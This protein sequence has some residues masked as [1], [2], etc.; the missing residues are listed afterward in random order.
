[1]VLRKL[2]Q[3]L[4]MQVYAWTVFPLSLP[5][6]PCQEACREPEDHNRQNSSDYLFWF[7]IWCNVVD[8][9]R[10]G[11]FF[12][13]IEVLVERIFQISR[14]WTRRLRLEEQR[15]QRGPVST[16]KTDR[17]HD[18]RQLSSDWRSW[19]SIRFSWFILRYSRWWPH[20]GIRYKM[21]RSCIVDVKISIRWYLG[22]SVQM[23][24]TWVCAAQNRIGIVRHGDSPEHIS[25]HL[26]KVENHGE[27][28]YRS[29]TSIAK[30]WRQ[31]RENWIRIRGKESKGIPSGKK[32]ASVRIETDAVSATKPKIVR[33]KT[34]THCRHTFWA[35][36]DTRSKCVEE[37]K[38]PRQK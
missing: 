29:E 6:S 22:K 16:R 3:S 37:K 30:L 13:R 26:S 24:N 11:W 20:S 27:E 8:Q 1:M 38:H 21:G 36:R 34:R 14:C 33:K 9:G 28:E 12:G 4:L 7:S 18:L 32:M 2:K 17:L 31:A 23:K 15:A 5:V 19:Y 10:G 25:S 35:N